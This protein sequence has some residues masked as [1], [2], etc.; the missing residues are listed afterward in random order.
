M[1]TALID[2]DLVAYRCSASVGDGDLDIAVARCDRLMQEILYSTDAENYLS[3]LTGGNNFRKKVNPEYKA[4]RKDKEPPKWLQ[5]CRGFL[6]TEWKSIVSDGIEA[7][8]LLGISQKEHTILASLDKDLQM[9]PGFHYNWVKQEK[10][11]VEPLAG[12]RH[13]YKQMLIG[14]RSDNIFGIDG[15]GPVKA[16]KIIDCLDNEMSMIEVISELYNDPKRFVMNAQCLWIMKN[17][18]ETWV[19]RTSIS[20]GPLK[21]EMDLLLDSMKSLMVDTSMEL[22]TNPVMTSGIPVN[23]ELTECMEPERVPLT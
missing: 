7:D 22:T 6:I 16:S 5:E 9:I 18:G 4:N 1:T 15:I 17:E 8:D 2:A 23:G 11:Y 3:F 19:K 13:F 14:D 20:D 10:T 12:L 21:Q